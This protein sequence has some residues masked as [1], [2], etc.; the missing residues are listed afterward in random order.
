MKALSH[1][2][3]YHHPG[4]E[5]TDSAPANDTWHDSAQHTEPA[6]RQR[7]RRTEKIVDR[8]AVIG[9]EPVT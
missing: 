7:F 3:N 8:W 4:H 5:E 1:D 9:G 6:E 2:H